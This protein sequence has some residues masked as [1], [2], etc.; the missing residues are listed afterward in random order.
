MD[1]EAQELSQLKQLL[2]QKFQENA[3]QFKDADLQLLVEK[4]FA[5]EASL[6]QARPEHLRGSPGKAV[7]PM[8]IEALLREFNPAPSQTG[9]KLWLYR[10]V[11]LCAR[12]SER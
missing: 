5:D 2:Q 12:S 3:G 1:S 4:G 6:K 7:K 8:L 10:S 11:E 9:I